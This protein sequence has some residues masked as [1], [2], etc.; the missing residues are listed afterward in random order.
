MKVTIQVGGRFHAFDLAFQLE[1]RGFLHKLITSY[2]K[3]ETVKYGIP[4]GKIESILVKEILQRG[5]KKI[6]G[7]L[8]SLYDPSPII[9]DI[10]DKLA[11][12]KIDKTDIFVGWTTKSLYSLRKAKSLGAAGVIEHGSAHSRFQ[13][14]IVE[15]EYAKYG[16]NKK[17]NHPKNVD[18]A[19]LEFEEADYISI[20]SLFAKRTFLEMGIPEDKLIHIPY[21]VDLSQFKQISKKDDVFRVVFVGGM[22]LQKG[23]HYLLRAFTELGL[24]NSE[25]ILLGSETPEIEPFFKKYGVISALEPGK[26]DGRIRFLG[27]KKQDSLYEYYSQ[28]SVFIL[29]SIHD[30]FGMVM[31][32][33]MASGLPV[34]ATENT[35]G[36][37]II[38]N[39]KQGF[40]IPIR[41]TESLKGKIS[42]LYENRDI[43]RE[44]GQLAK[45]KVSS[46]FTWDDYGDRIIKAYEG[47]LSKNK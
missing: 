18:K 24:P 35:G 12:R 31:T 39:G 23:V 44:M 26:G 22:T 20:P 33:A 3:F 1:K 28:G 21:G 30:G 36:P 15:E 17:K 7:F 4:R 19:E 41:D 10:F 6:P 9:N 11:R 47:I 46:G 40:I 29:P 37:D 38:E 14:E 8:K 27:H 13:K 34:I 32:Q 43:C 2:P 45:K 42:Y 16:I 25:L 5:W